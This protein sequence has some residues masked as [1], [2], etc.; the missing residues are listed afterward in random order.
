MATL[1]NGQTCLEKYGI[2]ERQEHLQRN[3]YTKDYYYDKPLIDSE[4][5]QKTF[6]IT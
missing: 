2:E 4:Y 3:W 6:K 5:Q 1:N